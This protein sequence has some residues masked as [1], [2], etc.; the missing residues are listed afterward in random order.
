MDQAANE[1]QTLHEVVAAAHRA[2]DRNMWDYG[3]VIK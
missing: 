3:P 1:F 2:L